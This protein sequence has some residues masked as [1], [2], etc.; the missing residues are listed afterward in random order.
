MR[1]G[2][3]DPAVVRGLRSVT[4]VLAGGLVVLAA[5][6]V[7]AEV[8]AVQRGAEGPGALGVAAHVAAAVLAVAAQLHA[9]IG[10]ASGRE[11]GFAG[12]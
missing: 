10:R 4:G 2:V 6:V 3:G 8:L 9:E 11:R 5:V 7:A 1:A 12:V